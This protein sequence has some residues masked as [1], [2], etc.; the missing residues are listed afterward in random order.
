MIER[1]WRIKRSPVGHVL[2]EV[3]ALLGVRVARWAWCPRRAPVVLVR[4]AS[5]EAVKVIEP[6]PVGQSSNG[7]IGLVFQTGTS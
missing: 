2:G 4:L 3:V 1:C 6:L 5:E 7:P